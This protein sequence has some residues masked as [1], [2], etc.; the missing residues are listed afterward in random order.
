ML[1]IILTLFG[2]LKLSH[3]LSFHNPSINTYTEIDALSGWDFDPV[4]NDFFMAFALEDYSSKEARDDPKFV[5][6]LATY[7]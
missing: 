1:M 5:K 3:L 4:E 6:W 2:L 7:F